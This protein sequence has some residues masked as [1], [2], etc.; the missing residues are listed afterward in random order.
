MITRAFWI[1]AACSLA[2]A[3]AS[4][5]QVAP[6]RLTLG[7]AARAAAQHS[8]VAEIARLR[9]DEARARVGLARSALLPTITGDVVQAGRTFNTATI[10][11]SLPG[12]DPNG[13]V[14]GPVNTIDFRGRIGQTIFD[15]SA[16]ARLNAAKTGVSASTAEATAAA[17]QSA[18]TASVAYVRALRAE[19]LLRSRMADS[20]LSADLLAIARDLLEAGVGIAL[21]VTRA[22]SQVAGTKAQLLSARND[23]A[24][25]RLE[26]LRA[27]GLPLDTPVELADTLTPP[28]TAQQ[29][30]EQE[31]VEAALR[32]RADVR[33]AEE[34]LAAI[35][36]QVSAIRAERLPSLGVVADQGLIGKNPAHVLPTYT[37]GLQLSIPVFDGARRAS[38]IAEQSTLAREV[39][40]RERD[41][42]AQIA[43]EVRG[44][45][46][47]LGSAREQVEAVRER[48][49]LAEQELAQARER[50]S[51]GVAGNADVITASLSLS[52]ARTSLVD[53]EAAYQSARVA[54]ARAQ[55][56]LTTIR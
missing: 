1:S 55:G 6:L 34:Q 36:S 37:W 42:R 50:F 21:D 31:A 12:F 4:Q 43:V 30:D 28:F 39:E 26:L 11:L 15:Q 24:R 56:T 16:R 8:A 44:A 47:D 32:Q 53:V 40:V 41:L 5:A 3:G 20:A 45:L 29:P 27:I 19:A 38:R 51:A 35:R 54:L 13:E 46:L 25:A 14:E 48:V 52:A 23:Q 49:R 17:E 33:A 2:A 22:Q 9:I 7:D 10:G 18:A